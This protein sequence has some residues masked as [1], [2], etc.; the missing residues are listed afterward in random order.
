M[1]SQEGGSTVSVHEELYYTAEHEWISIADESARVGI[2]DYAQRALGDVVYVTAP[3]PGTRV[4]AG[5]PCGEVEST[6]SV[7]DIYSPADGEVT[8]INPEIDEDPGLVNS[9]PYG[10]GWL[11]KLHLDSADLPPGL[12]SAAEYEALTQEEQ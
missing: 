7:S 12:L 2:T 8:E 9:D 10:A 5:D 6:K 1:P 11:F 3:A 4:T